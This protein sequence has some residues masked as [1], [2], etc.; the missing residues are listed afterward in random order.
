MFH[1]WS[2]KELS[3]HHN[4]PSHTPSNEIVVVFKIPFKRY[5]NERIEQAFGWISINMHQIHNTPC[6][7]R[8]C[9]VKKT[10][11]HAQRSWQN[12]LGA[13]KSQTW[14]AKKSTLKIEKN[15]SLMSGTSSMAMLFLTCSKVVMT[16]KLFARTIS[17]MLS[18]TI[19]SNILIDG[20]T[21]PCVLSGTQW[22]SNNWKR[23]HF[24][25]SFFLKKTMM[26]VIFALRSWK[27][28]S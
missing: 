14:T 9:Q 13:K 17:H 21:P 3:I 1:V 6:T 25:N 11:T 10:H 24:L 5:W 12:V 2:D 28:S 18:S 16:I 15:T 23:K 20:Y 22:Y 4:W 8:L 7:C 26:R 27:T 19:Y